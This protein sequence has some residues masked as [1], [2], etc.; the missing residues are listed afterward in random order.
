MLILVAL[1]VMILLLGLTVLVFWL[2]SPPFLLLCTGLLELLI[3]VILGFPSWNFLSFLSNGLDTGCSVKRR[4]GPMFELNRPILIPS[5]PV[6]EGIEIRHGC[7][8]LSSLLRAL[9][10]LPGG[11]GRFLPC[12][13]GTHLSRLRH[14]G[15][16]Q[17]S[18]GLDSRPLESCHHQCLKAVC[19]VLGYPKGSA[20]ELLDGTLKLRYCTTLFSKRFPHWSLPQVSLGIGKRSFS[21]IGHLLDID[22]TV[23][24]RVGL[25][26]KTRP[27][28]SS[29]VIPDPVPGHSTPR[30]W[31]RLLPL[32]PKEKGERWACL[33]IFFLA[34][35]LGDFALGNAW[36]LLSEATGVGGSGWTVSRRG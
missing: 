18:H 13:L 22:S 34:L 31:K 9:G 25:T 15:W 21:T 19:G 12:R 7:Q 33:A 16:N 4:L 36:N 35:G 14:V 23:G 17:C 29:H 5:V 27:D 26:K 2:G 3:Y 1:L 6:S 28:I 32:P 24:K 11:L 8:F 30:R 20:L 10:K